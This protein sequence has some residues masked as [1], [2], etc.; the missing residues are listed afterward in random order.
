MGN[1]VMT[2]VAPQTCSWS[3]AIMTLAALISPTAWAQVPGGCT[4]P[5]GERTSAVGC[6]VDANEPL[7][8]LPKE[9]V[10]WHL[11]NYPTRAAA[12][13]AKPP[14]GTV[15]ESFGKVWL[16]AIATTNWHPP[17]GQLVAVIGPLPISVGKQYTARYMES[18]YTPGMRA[19]VHQ[20]SG[21]EAFYVVSGTQCLETS[22]GMTLSHA[23]E[24]A[25][26][27]MGSSMTVKGV[28]EEARRA[29]II[30][31]HDSSQPWLT[32]TSD[33]TPKGLCPL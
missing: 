8:E 9:P 25:V 10:F 7:G 33:W 12:E 3:G 5:V 26:A 19:R 1:A 28:G 15:V 24:S 14:H 16:Y 13:S 22:D 31:L 6:Y 29:L 32:F 27:P 2:Q 23:G 11:Y 21:P 18:V 17:T 30:V 20:H 4:T